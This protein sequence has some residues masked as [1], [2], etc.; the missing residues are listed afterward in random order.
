VDPDGPKQVD[1]VHEEIQKNLWFPGRYKFIKNKEYSREIR[2]SK[3]QNNTTLKVSKIFRLG[4]FL[5][6]VLNVD[7]SRITGTSNKIMC[8]GLLLLL[9]HELSTV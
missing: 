8:E 4:N 7:S 5:L 3:R 9:L 1:R 2:K 6:M